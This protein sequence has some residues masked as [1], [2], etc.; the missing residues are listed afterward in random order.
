MTEKCYLTSRALQGTA[1]VLECRP[2]ED[3]R[4]AVILDKTLFHPQGGGQPR[5]YRH[6][7]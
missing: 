1:T 7:R 3:G 2:A 5:R 4:Y 6:T